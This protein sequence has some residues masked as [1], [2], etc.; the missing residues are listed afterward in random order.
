VLNTG[1][2]PADP[3]MTNTSTDNAISDA[4]RTLRP[5]TILP[6]LHPPVNDFRKARQMMAPRQ[7]ARPDTPSAKQNGSRKLP[8]H[9]ILSILPRPCQGI[10]RIFAVA[11]PP[12]PVS[13]PSKDCSVTRSC[14]VVR[15]VA[16]TLVRGPPQLRRRA[17]WSGEC[18]RY[19]PGRFHLLLWRC[20]CLHRWTSS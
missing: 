8:M 5:L 17:I 4:P 11:S 15:D 7:T 3:P 19:R 1:V 16:Q 2:A 9:S 20:G 6:L 18:R 13:Q 14:R 10:L 12:S